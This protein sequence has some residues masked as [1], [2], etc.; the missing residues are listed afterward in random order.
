MATKT[1]L[2]KTSL[3]IGISLEVSFSAKTVIMVKN[4]LRISM[5]LI[6]PHLKDSFYIK[7]V[8][9]TFERYM[10]GRCRHRAING[11]TIIVNKNYCR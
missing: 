8:K 1:H 11:A 5:S 10:S 3:G 9:S 6:I 2:N 4:K 7:S